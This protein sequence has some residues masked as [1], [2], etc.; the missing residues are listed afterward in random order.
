[1]RSLVKTIDHLECVFVGSCNLACEYC[2][3]HKNP[4]N[5]HL[6]NEEIR[7]SIVDGSFQNNI[8]TKF[9]EAKYNIK[10]LSLW[11]GEPTL[12]ADLIA[13]FC[14]PLLEFFPFLETFM[15][16]TNGLLGYEKGIKPYIEY[17]KK[18]SE[19]HDRPIHL[20]I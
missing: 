10:G 19:L 12:N 2:F 9:N 16:S 3:I 18:Y 8:I 7:N 1:M 14:E 17:F 5:M 4:S 13:T 11:S 15:F 6:Y 20:T